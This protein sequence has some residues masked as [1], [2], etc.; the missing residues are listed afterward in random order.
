MKL[1]YF[2]GPVMLVLLIGLKKYEKQFKQV[3]T[4]FNRYNF[5]IGSI[6]NKNLCYFRIAQKKRLRLSLKCLCKTLKYY[7]R[8]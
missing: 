8:Q 5:F 6:T 4:I 3:L 2:I 1:N 7:A